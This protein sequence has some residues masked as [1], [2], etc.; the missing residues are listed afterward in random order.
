MSKNTFCMVVALVNCCRS[1][2][3]LPLA[4]YCY[5]SCYHSFDH[6]IQRPGHPFD[7]ELW[8]CIQSENWPWV[9]QQ[10]SVLEL[11]N[12]FF[13]ARWKRPVIFADF[14]AEKCLTPYC[15]RF[16]LPRIFLVQFWWCMI[17]RS[18]GRKDRVLFL[19]PFQ[20]FFPFDIF[21]QLFLL[22]IEI[23]LFK[24]HKTNFHVYSS[25]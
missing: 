19:G 3:H 9:L 1:V 15:N 22:L 8:R 18:N 6:A 14:I 13:T 10:C 20:S 24:F 12:R 7:N 4:S 25:T 23:T 16:I 2:F 5:W 11:R 17:D 21:L